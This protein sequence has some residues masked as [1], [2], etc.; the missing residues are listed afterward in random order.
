M[1]EEAAGPEGVVVAVICE[2]CL[3]EIKREEALEIGSK[4]YCAACFYKVAEPFRG[5]L[6]PE[7]RRQL[8]A[9]VAQEMEGILPRGVLMDVVADGFNRILSQ[10]ADPEEELAHIVNRVEQVCGLAMSREVLSVIEALK[11]TLDQQE[12]ELRDK[13]RKLGSL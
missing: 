3:K 7:Q 12:E 13:V 6:T 2:T 1:V 11:T 5:S 10:K 4:G 8:K 9:I